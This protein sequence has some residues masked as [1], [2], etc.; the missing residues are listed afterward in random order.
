MQ[1][2]PG[3]SKTVKEKK[4]VKTTKKQALWLWPLKVFVLSVALSIV[5]SIGSEYFMSAT[6]VVVSSLI[7]V[8]LIA[9]AV[10]SDIIGVAFAA[11]QPEPFNSMSAR[12]V[13]GAKEALTLIK[14]ASKVS[15]ICNDVIGDI[16]GIVSGAAG[17]AIVGRITV[18]ISDINLTILITAT[19]SALIAGLTIS[20]KSIGKNYAM[21]KCDKIVLLVGMAL[22][23]FSK[24]ERN[25]KK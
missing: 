5:F 15:A 4:S 17:A 10:V 20:C 14:N 21:E 11:V 6:G 22:S 18:S 9:I 7:I 23:P 16:C 1:Q 13:R 2:E 3:Q 19:M 24:K 12:K 8:F 25:D